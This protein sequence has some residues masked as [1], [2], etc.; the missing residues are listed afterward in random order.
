MDIGLRVFWSGVDLVR[1]PTEKV[2][3]G[4]E[5]VRKRALDRE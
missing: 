5:V 4:V 3:N 2:S 1:D